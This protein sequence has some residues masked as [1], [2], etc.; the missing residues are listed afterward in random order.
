MGLTFFSSHYTLVTIEKLLLL[1]HEKKQSFHFLFLFFFPRN[2]RT[3]FP[4]CYIF[5]Y[6]I[7]IYTYICEVFSLPHLFT[8]SIHLTWASGFDFFNPSLFCSTTNNSDIVWFLCSY[9]CLVGLVNMS[10]LE[11]LSVYLMWFIMFL[12][13]IS[14]YFNGGNCKLYIYTHTHISC[15]LI[16]FFNQ[17]RLGWITAVTISISLCN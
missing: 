4:L 11:S 9:L 16:F 5:W 10:L 14:W 8:E 6:I 17:N 2:S 3:Q 1:F 15:D 13:K 12:A 7:Y